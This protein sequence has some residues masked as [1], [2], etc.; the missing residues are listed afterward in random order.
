[1]SKL[2]SGSMIAEVKVIGKCVKPFYKSGTGT[3]RGVDCRAGGIQGK[4]EEKAEAMDQALGA[5]EGQ[6]PCLRRLRE[7]PPVL[8]LCFGSYGEGSPGVHILVSLLATSRV[9]AL[10]LQGKDT[11]PNQMG[12][13]IATIRRRLSTAVVRANHT[14]LLGR[15]GQVGEGN[16]LAG[17]RRAFAR[18]EER[19]TELEQEADWLC[20]TSGRQLVQRGQFWRG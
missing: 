18:A 15:M 9:R 10:T 8:D 20:H 6:G 11:R 2:Y 19:R 17:K 3:M 7:F 4:Y 14:L 12:L 1:M 13:E 16:T 5:A